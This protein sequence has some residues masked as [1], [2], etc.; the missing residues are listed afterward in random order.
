M[1]ERG[2]K[3]GFVMS[4]EH[5]V[6]IQNSNILTALI[7]H[8]EGNRE[9]SATQVSAG[10]GLLKKIMPDLAAAADL[11]DAG[12]LRPVNGMTDAELEA[13]AASGSAGTPAPS[14]SP[15]KLN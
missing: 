10:L 7:E 6:K 4:N 9:M 13:I 5:R 11:G 1:A 2:R 12:E 14:Q 15:H 8:V 3:P